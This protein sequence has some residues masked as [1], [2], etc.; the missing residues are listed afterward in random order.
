MTEKI[1]AHNVVELAGRQYR[2]VTDNT[3]V[4]PVRAY[5]QCSWFSPEE[6]DFMEKGL[7]ALGLNPSVSLQYSHHPL[8]HQYNDIDVNEH[9]EVMGDRE[10][11]QNTYLLDENAMYGMEMGIGFFMPSKPDVGQAYEQGV[12]HALHKPN[13]LVIPDDEKN[14]PLNLMVGCGNTRIITLSEAIDFDFH[15]VMF[16]PYDGKVF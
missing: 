11:Q 12:L 15:D 8:S 2:D 16:K 9:P 13:V 6:T 1:L 10:W 4:S 5:I 3:I 14:I 7:E